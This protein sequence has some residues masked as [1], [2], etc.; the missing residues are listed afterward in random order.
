MDKLYQEFEKRA[1]AFKK[2]GYILKLDSKS[3]SFKLRLDGVTV[4]YQPF[5]LSYHSNGRPRWPHTLRFLLRTARGGYVEEATWYSASPFNSQRIE[6][7]GGGDSTVPFVDEIIAHAEERAENAPPKPVR[8]NS[9]S[10]LPEPHRFTA[11]AFKLHHDDLAKEDYIRYTGAMEQCRVMEIVAI[12]NNLKITQALRPDAE[13]WF[14]IDIFTLTGARL[15]IITDGDR[16]Y[17]INRRSWRVSPNCD[18]VKYT[19]ADQL[20]VKAAIERFCKTADK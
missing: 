18:D 17:Y 19:Q 3:G 20:L 16:Y 2:K 6:A 14:R 8:Y 5:I 12:A 13:P 11:P 4:R 7:A 1:A 15:E 9:K 10:K